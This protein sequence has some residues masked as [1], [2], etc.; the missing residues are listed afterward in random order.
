MQA[1]ED[2]PVVAPRVRSARARLIHKVYEVNHWVWVRC[3]APMHIIPMIDDA[4][5]IR[6]ILEDLGRLALRQ[7]RQTQRAPA[8]DGKGT[9]GSKRPVRKLSYHSVLDIAW[10]AERRQ[11]LGIYRG[12][13]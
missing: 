7:T 1:F 4:T 3:G 2:G 6:Q 10:V 12:A 11:R 5:L 13:E 8:G 9:D